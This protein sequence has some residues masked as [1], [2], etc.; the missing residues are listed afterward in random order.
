MI[1]K[2][3]WS[4]KLRMAQWL[5]FSLL[6]YAIATLLA[7]LPGV[8][9]AGLWPRAQTVLWKCGHLNLAAFLGYWI[10]RNSFKHG[11]LTNCSHPTC[12]IRRAIVI[13]CTMLAFGM[14]I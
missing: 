2:K 12:E 13:G 8:V 5:L 6:A 10:D 1:D 11:R 9:D 4:D 3:N 7:S 14:A